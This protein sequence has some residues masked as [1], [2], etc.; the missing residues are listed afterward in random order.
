MRKLKGKAT[1]L[2]DRDEGLSIEIEDR[3]SGVCIFCTLDSYSTLA[4]LSRQAY[5]DCEITFP[6]AEGLSVIGK[7]REREDYL[8]E[9]TWE[10]WNPSKETII[11]ACVEQGAFYD[12]WQLFSDGTRTQ[13]GRTG[14]HRIIL[15]RWV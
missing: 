7:K 8:L 2:F 10:E 4:A 1:L 13:Q 5:V 9:K 11:K 15:E 3:R 14:F 12:D 6:E